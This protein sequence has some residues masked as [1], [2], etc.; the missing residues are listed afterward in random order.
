MHEHAPVYTSVPESQV[1]SMTSKL[2]PVKQFAACRYCGKED[3][4]AWTN[5]PNGKW[6]LVEARYGVR[7]PD[8]IFADPDKPHLCNKAGAQTATP[9]TDGGEEG[10]V[11]AAA[12]RET[13]EAGAVIPLTVTAQELEALHTALL[14]VLDQGEN[15]AML[16]DEEH[17]ELLKVD[18]R[19]KGLLLDAGQRR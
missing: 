9:A 8:Q 1:I 18:D 4:L 3:G 16:S 5:A 14:L 6:R 2:V 13:L 15:E 19:V 11:R 17:R 12:A 10:V 7:H